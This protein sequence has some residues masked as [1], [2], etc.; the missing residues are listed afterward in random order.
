M[1]VEPGFGGQAFMEDQIIKIK[2]ISNHLKSNNL[3]VEIEI[4]GGVNFETGQKCIEAGA[5]V[6]VAGSFL[7]NQGDLINATNS[8]L[9]KFN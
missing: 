2:K 6:L 4:D 5:H 9:E 8:L 7:F 3:N 1:S